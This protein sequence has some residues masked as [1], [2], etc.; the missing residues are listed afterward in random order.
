MGRK[1]QGRAWRRHGRRGG[2][3]PGAAEDSWEWNGLST[4]KKSLP[5]AILELK[6]A[7]AHAA[8]ALSSGKDLKQWDKWGAP[9]GS[10]SSL[11]E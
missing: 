8:Y 10:A 2:V 4:V 11:W 1:P 5:K 9:T 7:D 6:P 3:E